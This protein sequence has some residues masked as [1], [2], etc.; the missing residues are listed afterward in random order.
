MSITGIP[1]ITNLSTFGNW[2]DVT[3]QISDSLVNVVTMGSA[4]T[5]AGEV[6]IQNNISSSN[7]V[8]TDKLEPYSESGTITLG[9][10]VDISGELSSIDV[11]ALKTSGPDSGIVGLEMYKGQEPTWEIVTDLSHRYL[12]IANG[13]RSVRFDNDTGEVL[14]TNF[15]LDPNAFPA[16]IN[17]GVTGNVTGDLFGDIYSTDKTSKV[18]ESGVNGNATFYGNV[19]GNITSSGTSSFED[20]DINGGTIDGTPIGSTTRSTIRA[21]SI[22]ASTTI[23]ATSTITASGGFFG[24]VTGTVSSLSNHTTSALGEGTNLYFT[25]ARAREA[26]SNDAE[27]VVRYNSDTGVISS[28]TDSIRQL[29]SDDGVIS[30]NQNTGVISSSTTAI[31]GLFS[32][33][34]AIGI[35]DGTISVSQSTVRGWFSGGTGVG[36][37]ASGVISIGQSVAT[38]A[39]VTFGE[40]RSTGDVTAFWTASDLKLKEN[41]KKIENP[42]E[43]VSQISGYTFNYKGKDEEMTGVIAQEV[44]KVLPGVV[45]DVT[46]EDGDTHKAVRYGTM[47][48]LLI[49]AIKELQSKVEDLESRVQ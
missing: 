40:V 46:N 4:E 16:S 24:N 25:T 28:D 19:E 41:I 13:A 49:E 5:N 8:F 34:T 43:K 9:S 11:H 6:V 3:N 10:D 29:F 23:S 2:K 45:Y 20:I 42:L 7:T 39:T 36:V 48:G 14:F 33:G 30:Y 1:E 31:R 37:N 27:S 17:T 26:I 15:K 35:T 38:T 22:N 44:E 18:L 32:G 12:E 47:V 21:T